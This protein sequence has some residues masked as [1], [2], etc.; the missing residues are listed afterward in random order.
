LPGGVIGTSYSQAV[1]A[2]SAGGGTGPFQFS[3]SDGALPPGLSLAQNG[4]LSGAPT[5][6]GTYSFTI[7]ATILSS[8]CP[9]SRTYTLTVTT[10][11]CPTVTVRVYS[12]SIFKSGVPA[13][14]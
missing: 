12:F 3:L 5:T 1:T 13:I 14:E 6:A 11:G 8:L 2:S 10:V 7:T 9:G 4:L